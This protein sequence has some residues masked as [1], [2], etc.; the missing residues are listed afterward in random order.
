MQEIR[1]LVYIRLAGSL[2][3]YRLAGLGKKFV[4]IEITE[5]PDEV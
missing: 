1:A 4:V 2:D 3:P 5:T